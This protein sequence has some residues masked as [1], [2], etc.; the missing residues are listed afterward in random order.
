M[1][2]QDEY[3]TELPRKEDQI[4]VHN[5]AHSQYKQV[6]TLFFLDLLLLYNCPQSTSN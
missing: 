5:N 4:V 3:S 6:T 2:N 1:N